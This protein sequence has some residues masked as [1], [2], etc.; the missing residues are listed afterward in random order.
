MKVHIVCYEDV[1][2]WIIGKFARK[3]NDNLQE[4]GIETNIS[5][6][7]DLTADINHHLIYNS[8]NGEKTTKDSLMITHINS[9]SKLNWI[10]EK[11][12]AAVVGICM[13]RETVEY[14]VKMGID[15]K[16]L[17]YINPAHDGNMQI[18]KIVIGIASRIYPDGRKN[19]YYF[20][21]LAEK[22]DPVFF[23]FKIM[24]NGWEPQV[25]T[26]QQ[27]KFEIDYIDHFD[28]QEYLKFIPSL[29]YYLY[30]GFDE[31]QIGFVDA[32]SAGVKTIVTPQGYHLD[33]KNGI[34]HSF[35][36]YD[37]LEDILLNLQEEKRCLVE[38]VASWNW[39]DYTLKHVEIWKYLLGETKINSIYAD[40]LNTLISPGTTIPVDKNELL[41]QESKLIKQEK[42]YLKKQKMRKI[43]TVFEENGFSGMIIFLL[44][45]VKKR[46]FN[47]NQNNLKIL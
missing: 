35:R 13:S 17:C 18:K 10:R 22:L 26:L 28:Y 44:L 21:K 12:K 31:G 7:P 11:I 29:D 19:E 47:A 43:R 3:I 38:S 1:D 33:A 30:T 36:N 45:K 20:D 15:K 46:L 27:H 34:T 9:I 5:N 25:K 23:K 6:V 2:S 24:G 37:N 16:K 40:G 32:L 41:R 8:F 42:L 39:H 4:M 14:L